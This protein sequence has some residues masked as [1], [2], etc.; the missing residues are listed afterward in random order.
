MQMSA[1]SPVARFLPAMEQLLEHTEDWENFM[2]GNQVWP[3]SVI[4]MTIS[5]NGSF[6]LATTG[7]DFFTRSAIL[8]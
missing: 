5:R 6:A 7:W 4:R 2:T 3:D 1:E 8:R